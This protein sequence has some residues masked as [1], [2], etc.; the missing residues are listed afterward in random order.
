MDEQRGWFKKMLGR[1]SS[2]SQLVDSFDDLKKFSTLYDAFG[3]LRLNEMTH[4]EDFAENPRANRG[5][6]P[7]KPISQV[8]PLSALEGN[9]HSRLCEMLYFFSFK[10]YAEL[11]IEHAT[12]SA[13]R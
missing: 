3:W 1:P 12:L 10:K 2:P 5:V 6:S 4:K 9:F 8:C 13:N 7:V 11:I